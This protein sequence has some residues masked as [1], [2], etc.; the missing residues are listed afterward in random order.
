MNPVNETGRTVIMRK[1][2]SLMGKALTGYAIG[3]AVVFCLQRW[4]IYPVHMIPADVIAEGTMTPGI[5]EVRVPT[6]DGETLRAYWKAPSPGAP[7]VVSFHGNAF[8]PQPLADRFSLPPWSDRGYGV[9]AIAYRGYPGSTGSPSE[10]GLLTD[11]RAALDWAAREAPAS[12]VVI[13]GHSLGAAVAV[14]MATERPSLALV[15]EAPF[16]SIPSLLWERMPFV[17]GFLTLDP[18]RSD[19][20]IGRVRTSR[21]MIVHGTSDPV[22]PH[23]Q[24]ERLVSVRPDAILRLLE[25]HD[26]ASLLGA[27]DQFLIKGIH[28]E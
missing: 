6:S 23:T 13:H 19:E 8:V 15:L 12:P 3:M 26:H 17:P 25:G 1:A 4:L 14:A 7:V 18:F 16:A 20:R 5:K 9:L 22:I 10:E 27:A 24:S 28:S 11:G 2:A 21:I